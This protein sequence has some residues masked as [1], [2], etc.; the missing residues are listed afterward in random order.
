MPFV[1]IGAF[2]STGSRSSRVT[3]SVSRLDFLHQL[4]LILPATR[5]V[6]LFAT[7]ARAP[8]RLIL[9]TFLRLLH[10]CTRHR[11]CRFT[12][13]ADFALL[14]GLFNTRYR[15]ILRYVYWL[16][17]THAPVLPH[18]CYTFTHTHTR[19]LTFYYRLPNS[20]CGC[21]RLFVH[22]FWFAL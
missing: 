6:I 2:Y 7:A 1:L 14:V 19:S 12:R 15:L 20:F 3:R 21:V 16:R 4:R 5:T 13:F 17:D 11:V 9:V 22:R 8:P 10:C 18:H